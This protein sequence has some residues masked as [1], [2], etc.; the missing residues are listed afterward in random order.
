MSSKSKTIARHCVTF[1]LHLAPS[2]DTLDP[3]EVDAGQETQ[4]SHAAVSGQLEPS[5]ETAPVQERIANI[6]CDDLKTRSLKQTSQ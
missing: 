4:C 1:T 5:L 2:S 6:R 3:T